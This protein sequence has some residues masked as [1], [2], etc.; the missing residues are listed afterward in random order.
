M[1]ILAPLAFVLAALV[2]VVAMAGT[3]LRYRDSVL[4]NLATDRNVPATCDF[5]FTVFEFGRQPVS[6]S[7]KKIR[8]IGRRSPTRRLVMPA[9]WRAAA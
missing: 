4:A 3:V 2:S 6:A 5:N 7:D 8:Q 9:G 1:S